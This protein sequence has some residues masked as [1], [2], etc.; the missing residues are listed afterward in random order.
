[1]LPQ[2]LRR[3]RPFERP[4]RTNGRH[5]SGESGL[6]LVRLSSRVARIRLERIDASPQELMDQFAVGAAIK[7][8]RLVVIVDGRPPQGVPPHKAQRIAKHQTQRR[9]RLYP[10]DSADDDGMAGTD[11]SIMRGDTRLP[12]TAPADRGLCE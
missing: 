12:A 3:Q 7:G 6:D 8:Y 10:L 2:E 1:M 4:L 11:P 5:G 9:R